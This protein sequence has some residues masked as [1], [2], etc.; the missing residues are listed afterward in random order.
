VEEAFG[1][2]YQSLSVDELL[3]QMNCIVGELKKAKISVGRLENENKKV[4]LY[5][6]Q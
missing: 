2:K 4:R 1:R 3:G 5:Y 6:L